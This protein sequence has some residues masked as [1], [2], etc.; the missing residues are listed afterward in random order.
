MTSEPKAPVRHRLTWIEM[1]ISSLISLTASLVLS[2]D[3]WKLAKDPAVDLGCN[4]SSTISCGT[5]AQAW[6]STLL[7][8][9]NAFLGL[10][11]EPVVITV[12]IA[13]L[14]GV[15][16]PRLFMRIAV[17]IYGIGFLFAYWL[18]YQAYF[19]IGAL[20]PW[21]LLVTLSTTTVFIT[22][23]RV[24]VMDDLVFPEKIREKIKVGLKYNADTGVAVILIAVIISAI[25]SKYS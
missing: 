15:T 23:F 18:F 4:I 17:A 10:I 11:A 19:E 21:C 13:G 6:Q 5:V 9:P 12:A 2:I 1:L 14:A 22:M 24:V 20:C 3:A 16:F 25:I 7:G 8:F